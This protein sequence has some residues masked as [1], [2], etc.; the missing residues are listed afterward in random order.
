MKEL[1][2]RKKIEKLKSLSGKIHIVDELGS[3]STS[4]PKCGAPYSSKPDSDPNSSTP[5]IPFLSVLTSLKQFGQDD[6]HDGDVAPINQLVNDPLFRGFRTVEKRNP[7][8]GVNDDH[9]TGGPAFSAA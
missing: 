1:I 3:E 5:F 9:A 2:R 4:F 8:G 7:R 6:A